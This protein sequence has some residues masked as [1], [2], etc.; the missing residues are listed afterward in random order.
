MKETRNTIETPQTALK[1]LRAKCLWCACGSAN[2]VRLCEIKDCPLYKFRS[3]KNP[4]IKRELT[5]AQ[6]EAQAE[7]LRVAR[8]KKEV[9]NG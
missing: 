1:A 3:G 9:V 7:R 2:E 4:N 5:P 6:R 8:E